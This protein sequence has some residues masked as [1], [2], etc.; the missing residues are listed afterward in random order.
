[1]EIRAFPLT[2]TAGKSFMSSISY[3]WRDLMS[4]VTERKTFSVM[5]SLRSRSTFLVSLSIM[6]SIS[7]MFRS[8]VS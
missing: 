7:V 5:A 8:P 1:M 3:P 6:L 4:M 2:R